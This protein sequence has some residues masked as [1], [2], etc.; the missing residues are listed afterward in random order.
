MRWTFDPKG[1][2]DSFSE[3]PLDDHPGE[4]PRL[5]ERYTAL[6]YR[7]GWFQ[8]GLVTDAKRGREAGRFTMNPM[9][10]CAP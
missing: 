6:P 7:H 3:T 1:K 2:S 4:F 10:P 5:D 9:A 8:A